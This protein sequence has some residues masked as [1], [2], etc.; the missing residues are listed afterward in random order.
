MKRQQ[1]RTPRPLLSVSEA[2]SLLG[3]SSATVR[4]YLADGRFPHVRIG[5][6]IRIRPED[7]DKFIEVNI[8][9]A[10]S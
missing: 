6:L 1:T 7:L 5:R 8:V 9:S 4:R 10:D 3:V 2:G